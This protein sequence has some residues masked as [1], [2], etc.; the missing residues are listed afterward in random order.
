MMPDFSKIFDKYEALVAEV[1]KIFQ[2]VQQAHPD[3]MRCRIHCADCCHAVFDLTLVEA[4]YMN[5]KFIQAFDE[6]AREPILTRAETMDRQYYKVKRKLQKMHID[7]GK[8]PEE[9][10]LALSQER[11]RCPLLNDEDLCELY[12]ARPITC[13][14][15][16]IPTSIGGKPHICEHANFQEG[17]AYPTVNL[18][19]MNDRLFALSKELLEEIGSPMQQMQISLVPPSVALITEYDDAYFGI[20]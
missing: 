2:G 8:S 5:R 1:D 9:V 17:T 18:D 3:C 16:G 20:E 19:K 4:V 11:I 10:L 15:Y 7:E 14:V 12:E 6:K 13:R